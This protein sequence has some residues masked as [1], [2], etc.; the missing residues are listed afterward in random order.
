M[1]HISFGRRAV[2]VRYLLNTRHGLMSALCFRHRPCIA[3][4]YLFQHLCGAVEPSMY[5]CFCLIQAY[6]SPCDSKLAGGKLFAPL[7]AHDFLARKDRPRYRRFLLCDIAYCTACHRKLHRVRSKACLIVATGVCGSL[8][9]NHR[10]IRYLHHR[11]MPHDREYQKFIV[12]RAD[13][14][15]RE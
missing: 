12:L 5:S 6:S 8:I 1:S 15:G 2:L 9:T 4:N 13:L 7:L 3:I 14:I 10:I 11:R